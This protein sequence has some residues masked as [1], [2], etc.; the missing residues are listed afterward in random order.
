MIKIDSDSYFKFKLLE[1]ENIFNILE[2]NLYEEYNNNMLKK[3]IQRLII[4]LHS[5]Q[6][7]Q[8]E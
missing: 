8:S 6:L 1:S 7:D 2:L 4:I 3:R 5:N